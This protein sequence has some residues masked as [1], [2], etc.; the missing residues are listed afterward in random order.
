MQAIKSIDGTPL[1]VQPL[2]DGYQVMK[3][4]LLADGSRRSTETGKAIR[5]MIRPGTY[6]LTLKFKDYPEKIAQVESLV[7]KL[8]ITVEFLDG[9]S[10]VTKQM[11]PGD[12]TLTCNGFISELSVNLIEV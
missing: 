11:Y 9:D 5:Y 1:A 12:R 3:S 6:K 7:S 8:T 10:Y 4:D 2:R